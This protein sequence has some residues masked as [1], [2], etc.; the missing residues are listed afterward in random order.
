M[1]RWNQI[2]DDDGPASEPVAGSQ[3]VPEGSVI[4]V[5]SDIGE[6][7]LPL[8]ELD[9][10]DR[11]PRVPVSEFWMRVC[12]REEGLRRGLWDQNRVSERRGRPTVGASHASLL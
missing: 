6:R 2:H 7:R 9:T 3:K 12:S 8:G 1:P 11:Q 10:E 5:L 4:S